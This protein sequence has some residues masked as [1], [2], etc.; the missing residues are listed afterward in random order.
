MVIRK[1]FHFGIVGIYLWVSLRE[2]HKGLTKD[3]LIM[4]VE[5]RWKHSWVQEIVKIGLKL[6]MIFKCTCISIYSFILTPLCLCFS[7]SISPTQLCH[8]LP[9]FLS[10]CLSLSPSLS[11]SL[12]VKCFLDQYQSI[13]H[14]Y[15]NTK[16]TH[17]RN[18][19]INYYFVLILFVILN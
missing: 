11:L 3:R 7:L 19:I 12:A 9:V 4:K 2:S 8:C 6:G 13:S 17:I 14:F 1:L 18:S 16:Q 10:L 15:R 5:M